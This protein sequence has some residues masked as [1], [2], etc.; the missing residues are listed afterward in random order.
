MSLS[1]REEMITPIKTMTINQIIER[2]DDLL[3]SVNDIKEMAKNEK[4]KAIDDFAEIVIAELQKA[5]DEIKLC[6][7]DL[8]VYRGA[9]ICAIET[10]KDLK[11]KLQSKPEF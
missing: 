4:N 10:V 9:T 3:V 7:N 8:D 2:K 1:E 11:G 6:E 5:K